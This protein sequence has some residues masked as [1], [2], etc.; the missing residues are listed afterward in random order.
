MSGVRTGTLI[1]SLQCLLAGNSSL[2]ASGS[3]ETRPERQNGLRHRCSLPSASQRVPTARSQS[4]LRDR[5]FPASE[6]GSEGAR[7]ESADV[8]VGRFTA[9]PD[10]ETKQPWGDGEGGP[11]GTSPSTAL[12]RVATEEQIPVL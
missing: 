2:L 10:C 1:P 4:S 5:G 6:E 3:I 7:L 9:G 8:G 11:H 12:G